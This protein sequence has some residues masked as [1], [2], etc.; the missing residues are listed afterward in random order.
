MMQWNGKKAPNDNKILNRVFCVIG[1]QLVLLREDHF[2]AYFTANKQTFTTSVLQVF[3][4]HFYTQKK[5]FIAQKKQRK[6]QQK[7]AIKRIKIFTKFIFT[8]SLS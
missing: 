3:Q 5:I 8:S 7:Q 4:S 6:Y 2:N 1:N